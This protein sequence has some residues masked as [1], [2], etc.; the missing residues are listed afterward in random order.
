[1][2]QAIYYASKT[3]IEAQHNYTTTEK[4]LFACE[5]FKHYLLGT[6]VIVYIDHAAIWYLFG[7]K[8]AK[9]HLIRWV[10]LLQEFDL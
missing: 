2:F 4:Q 6:K 10:L 7:K 3:L 8:D 1:M 9:L 5:K